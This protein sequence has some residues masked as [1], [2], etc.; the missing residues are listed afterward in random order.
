MLVGV[1]VTEQLDTV[2]LMLANV[3]GDPVNDPPE[4][5][6][7]VNPTVPPGDDG[8]PD[9]VSLTKAVQLVACPTTIDDGEQVTTVDVVLLAPTVTVLLVPELPK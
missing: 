8:V 6:V 1:K 3:Q 2:E 7:L 5:P 9:A 4:V